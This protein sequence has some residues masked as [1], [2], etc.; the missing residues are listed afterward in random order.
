MTKRSRFQL[1]H[2]GIKYDLSQEQL[3]MI[4]KKTL[5]L[6]TPLKWHDEQ[7]VKGLVKK[8]LIHREQWTTK[9][10]SYSRTRLGEEIYKTLSAKL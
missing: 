7:R 6:K 3:D 5:R 2:N 9:T 8:R 1:A 4:S 10:V